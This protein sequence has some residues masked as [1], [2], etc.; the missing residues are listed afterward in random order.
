MPTGR[1]S[2]AARQFHDA[3]LLRD[4]GG[5]SDG[6][7]LGTFVE[8]RGEAAFAAL[9]RRHGPMVMGVCRRVLRNHHDAE[10]AFQAT[11]VILARK[12]ASIASR[13]LLANWL[14]GVAYRAAIKARAVSDRRRARER[15]VPDVPEPGRA[16]PD[17]PHDL[18]PLLDRELRLL[19]DKYRAVVVL[20]DLEGK[21]RAEAARTL[22]VPDGTV[23][24]R[25]ARARAMLARRLT[26]RGVAVSAGSLAVALTEC[27]APACVPASVAYSTVKAAA[28]TAVPVEGV[29]TAMLTTKIK[30]ATAVTLVVFG[31]VAF[32]GGQ[33]APQTSPSRQPPSVPVG[34]GSAAR[35]DAPSGPDAV[36]ADRH[37]YKSWSWSNCAACHSMEGFHHVRPNDQPGIVRVAAG[38]E[39]YKALFNRVL[40]VLVEE[41]TIVNSANQ[42]DGRIEVSTA[43]ILGD[44]PVASRR[45][46][47]TITH[48]GGGYAI[49][50]QVFKDVADGHDWKMVGRDADL[51]AAIL[52]RL[53]S[54]PAQADVASRG[55]RGSDVR[56]LKK[57]VDELREKVKDLER[58]LSE[59]KAV[60]RGR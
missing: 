9:V 26:G 45:G 10:D 31:T 52:R 48:D 23:A 13:E 5:L 35:T 17:G 56:D 47:A 38:A 27:A 40:G 11:F 33:L 15:P 39:S 18:L 49:S 1:I 16:E 3:V 7:L 8:Q 46:V 43:T 54:R 41:F 37:A 34:S 21:T 14:Y 24:G 59:G 55:S 28:H 42:Y 29:L 25:L 53:D 60:P 20:C 36:L 57:E 12:A 58:R 30:A 2:E 22:G 50:V 19:P 44:R 32:G 4:G 51:E 6:Q